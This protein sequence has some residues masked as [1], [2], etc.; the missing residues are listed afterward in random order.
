[1]QWPQQELFISQPE[2]PP[3]LLLQCLS[4][5]LQCLESLISA[6]STDL[7]GNVN[8]ILELLYVLSHVWHFPLLV[9]YRGT[10]QGPFEK[11]T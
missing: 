7:G 5:M 11:R 10:L 8:P 3:S 4:A 2:Q 1:M 6:E 9:F